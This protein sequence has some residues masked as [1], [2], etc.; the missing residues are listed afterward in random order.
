[1]D[2]LA[3]P[4][5]VA[6]LERDCSEIVQRHDRSPLVPLRTVE[7]ES[8]LESRLGFVQISLFERHDSEVREPRGRARLVADLAAE[9]NALLEERSRPFQVS[10]PPFDDPETVER[11]CDALLIPVPPKERKAS[12]HQLSGALT[13][14]ALVEQDPERIHRA[15]TQL[16]RRVFRSREQVSEAAAALERVTVRIPEPA[17]RS[18]ESECCPFVSGRE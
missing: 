12:L 5:V 18:A 7:L 8:L 9:G 15:G 13:L 2:E 4:A 3:C 6:S 16:F 14:P 17:E 1:L 11:G 10:E